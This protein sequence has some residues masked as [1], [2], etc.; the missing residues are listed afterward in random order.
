[1]P[2]PTFSE[3]EVMKTLNSNH[4][5]TRSQIENAT[6]FA[7]FGYLDPYNTST[8]TREYVFFS[9]PDLHLISIDKDAG[10]LNPELRNRP[11]FTD[12]YNRNINSMLQLQW[13]AREFAENSPFCNLLTNEVA[14]NL[15]LSDISL[16]TLETSTNID[17]AKLEYP[18]ATV[19]SSNI[20]EFNLEFNDTK[21]LDTYMVFR[22]WY[23]YE[24]LKK[25]GLVTP[26]PVGG[27]KNYYIVNKILYDVMSCYKI[28]VGEDGETII[29]WAKYWGVFPTSIPRSTFGNVEGP[30]KISVSFK[31]QWVEDMDPSILDDFNNLVAD[32]KK[33]HNTDIPIYNLNDR[34]VDGTWCNVPYITLTMN[35]GK[36]VYKLKWR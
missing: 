6:K 27:D 22:I 23:E 10:S 3:S 36:R 7:R 12:A 9:K 30:I 29:Y 8:V 4:I 5:Y 19:T 20:E 24:L 15:E 18:L 21:Y 32:K 26:P 14:S 33:S 17:G 35:N 13:S 1:M 31:A 28:I 25:D 34:M 16:D 2:K 11:F